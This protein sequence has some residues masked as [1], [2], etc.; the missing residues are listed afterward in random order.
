MNNEYAVRTYFDLDLNY[1]PNN[2]NFLNISNLLRSKN[3]EGLI[4]KANLLR[5]LIIANYK[6]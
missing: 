5:T 3:R 1:T 2:M 6:Y 4:S